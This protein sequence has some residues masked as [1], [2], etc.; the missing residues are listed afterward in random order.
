MFRASIL[1]VLP[2]TGAISWLIRVTQVNKTALIVDDS[3]SARVV[4]KRVLETHDLEVDTSESAE[5]A[6]DYLID[7]RPDVIFMDHLMPGMDG[8]E[9]VSAIKKN[10]ETAT[11]PI[12][13]YTSKK[14][15][16]YVGQARALGAVGVLP[17][18]VAPVEV[19]KVLKSLHIIGDQREEQSG[20]QAPTTN[21][22]SGEYA[23]LETPDQNLRILIQDLFEQQRAIIHRD[24]LDS[25][26]A[27]STRIADEIRPSPAE[28]TDELPIPEAK[29]SP[30]FMRVA[31]VALTVSTVIFAWL[32]WQTEQSLQE[33]QTHN[34][35]LQGAL[36]SQRISHAEELRRALESQRIS[37]AEDSLQVLGQIGDFQQSLDTMY[38]VT[39]SSLEWGANQAVQYQFGDQPLDDDRLKIVE[40]LADQ[41]LAIDFSGVVRIETHV[42]NYCLKVTGS[43]GY[44]PAEDLR[45]A[46]CDRIGVTPEEAYATGLGQSV[47][48]ANFIRLANRRSGGEIRYE[49]VSL[50]NTDP[51]L[52][53]PATTDGVSANAWN[54]IAA[55]NNRVMISV[56]PDN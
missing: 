56:I 33:I 37:D 39:I 16:V 28:E 13:M 54:R 41:L 3:R 38:A 36:E 24:I 18:E 32:Y 5:E 31:A 6:L 1:P 44:V 45:A 22:I 15:E 40:Q 43:V 23:A 17:K 52:D 53:Y 11:I 49:I 12:M 25:Y 35:E 19:S 51:L 10:P 7:N 27:I 21:A 50:G 47:A 4:L 42:A 55:V 8:F 30:G 29:A 34:N 48:F 26:E 14:G 46:D 9:A 2:G 20:D